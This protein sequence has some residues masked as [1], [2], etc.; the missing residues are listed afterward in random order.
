[1]QAFM[2]KVRLGG[3]FP[4]DKRTH[5]ADEVDDTCIFVVPMTLFGASLALPRTHSDGSRQFEGSV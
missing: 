4:N 3:K 5:M 1:M 2:R